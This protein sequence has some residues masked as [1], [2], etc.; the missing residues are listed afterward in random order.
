[1]AKVTGKRKMRSAQVSVPTNHPNPP[2]EHEVEAAW[3]LAR[4]FNC[5]VEFLIPVDD[6]KRTTPD[7]VMLGI[8]WEVK[9]PKGTSRKYTIKDQFKRAS[10]QSK[11]II[12]D[13]RRTKLSDDFIE[14]AIRYELKTRHQIK[15][16]LFINK[17]ARVVEIL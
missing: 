10:K 5:T 12:I 11:N 2:A 17:S 4:H 7:I 8:L 3:I 1:V 16:L 13:G 14:N 15:R 6:Y 9:A